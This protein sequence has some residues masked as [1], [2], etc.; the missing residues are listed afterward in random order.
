[1]TQHVLKM[2]VG[3]EGSTGITQDGFRDLQARNISHG[4]AE[5]SQWVLGLP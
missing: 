3:L 5:K 4:A 1:M 2:D